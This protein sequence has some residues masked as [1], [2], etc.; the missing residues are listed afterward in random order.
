MLTKGAIG[1]LVNRY[2]A[3]LKKCNLINTFG[4]LAVASMLVLGGAG[5]AGAAG[6]ESDTKDFV[7]GEV[8]TQFNNGDVVSFTGG[9]KLD[10]FTVN[11]DLVLTNGADIRTKTLIVRGLNNGT[12]L[13]VENL[14]AKAGAVSNSTLDGGY[15]WNTKTLTAKTI[16]LEKNLSNNGGTLTV[17]NLTVG[18]YAKNKAGSTINILNSAQVEEEFHNEGALN[19]LGGNSVLNNLLQQDGGHTTVEAKASL[20]I[21]KGEFKNGKFYNQ[22]GAILNKGTLTVSNA[23]FTNN[24]SYHTDGKSASYG[25]AICNYL[26]TADIS[27]STFTGNLADSGAGNGG[28]IHSTGG[29]TTL[30]GNTF[31]GNTARKMGGAVYFAG[32][33]SYTISGNTFDGNKANCTGAVVINQSADTY[34]ASEGIFENNVFK[35]NESLTGDT[36]ALHIQGSGKVEAVNTVNFKG[37]NEFTSNKAATD[38][39]A[40]LVHY[41]GAVVNFDDGS[42]TTF[43]K[44]EA[45]NR[46]GAIYNASTTINANNAEFSGNSAKQGGAI[47]NG[48]YS[49]AQPA[50]I[51]SLKDASFTGNTASAKGGAIYNVGTLTINNATFTENKADNTSGGE[52][53]GGAIYND[54]DLVVSNSTFTGNTAFLTEKGAINTKQG[55]GGAIYT[56]LSDATLKVSDSVFTGNKA[57]KIGGAIYVS[58]STA[59][60]TGNTFDSNESNC[61]GV[62]YVNTANTTF[63]GNTFKNNKSL[64]GEGGAIVL[65][66]G[67]KTAITAEFTDNTFSGNT[68]AT[69]GG[70]LKI[71]AYGAGVTATLK[72]NNT[73][74]G[75]TAT[76]KGGAI[77]NAGTLIIDGNTTFS[78]NSAT[79]GD[80]IYNVGTLIINGTAALDG[81]IAG[82]GTM[83]GTGSVLFSNAET[84]VEQ[85]SIGK[86][87]TAQVSGDVNDKIGGDVSKYTDMGFSKVKMGEGDVFGEVIADGDKVVRKN[88]TLMDA[89]L[90]QASVTTVALDKILTN[91]VRKRLGD[92]RSDKNTTGVWMRWDGGKLQGNGLSNEFNTIQIGG[93][94]KV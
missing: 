5:M 49:S 43:N 30:S 9:E 21:S 83:D 50:G 88:N 58:E 72:G 13:Q 84:S 55:H 41:Q 8:K 61:A 11:H 18:T 48:Y 40:M 93:D 75:N 25:G 42:K 94:T 2:R 52:T 70:A 91:D 32:N 53:W 34:K 79:E 4:S 56:R 62:M 87:L 17:D 71:L 57:G 66:A 69:D 85:A 38:G 46:G 26:A 90:Q 20:N 27:N 31:T 44:N 74:S 39:G 51:V 22:G 67:E 89:A 35:N 78:G 60:F 68:A 1:N 47:Y 81:G 82:T 23:T 65:Q 33:A 14:V 10:S 86:T 24:T 19:F 77:Y 6:I 15:L 64:T 36:G 12:D 29:K 76:D 45:G 54:G 73:F 63:T 80:D 59:E 7:I 37:T 92:I 28:A 16:T 3:V